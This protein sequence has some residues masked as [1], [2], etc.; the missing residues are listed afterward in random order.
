MWKVCRN[1]FFIFLFLLISL[2]GAPSVL[3]IGE[4]I[5]LNYISHLPPG[6]LPI[7]GL[8]FLGYGYDI[9][10]GLDTI[11]ALVRP[12]LDWTFTSNKL[13]TYPANTSIQVSFF[14]FFSLLKLFYLV[15]CS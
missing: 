7:P 10:Y 13:Y 1:F 8:D 14:F 3:V 5:N 15:G 6:I 2:F 12:I 11:N 9:R 4:T